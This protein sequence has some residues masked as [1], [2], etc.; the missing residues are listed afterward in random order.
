MNGEQNFVFKEELKML[1]T[2]FLI[3]GLV[4]VVVVLC[5]A[6]SIGIGAILLCACIPLILLSPIYIGCLI[7]MKI[8]GY[9]QHEYHFLGS[10]IKISLGEDDTDE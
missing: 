1:E 10:T 7:H 5:I 9:K 6:F 8:K 4:I 3:I 2:I